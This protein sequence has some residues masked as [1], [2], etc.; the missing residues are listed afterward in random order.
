L[1][2]S[3]YIFGARYPRQPTSSKSAKKKKITIAGSAAW[4]NDP[5]E[6]WEIDEAEIKEPINNASPIATG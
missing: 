5:T 3:E 1:I 2:P 6:N 4:I